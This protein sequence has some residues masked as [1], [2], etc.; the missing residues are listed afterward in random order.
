MIQNTKYNKNVFLSARKPKNIIQ[1]L[2]KSNLER[3]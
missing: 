1:Q 2:I 3:G